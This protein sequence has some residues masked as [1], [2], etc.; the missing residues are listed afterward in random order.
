MREKMKREGNSP[1]LM[2]QL[3]K[4]KPSGIVGKFLMPGIKGDRNKRNFTAGLV[5]WESYTVGEAERERRALKS[6]G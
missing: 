2:P 1:T 3:K 6:E 5:M 4:G